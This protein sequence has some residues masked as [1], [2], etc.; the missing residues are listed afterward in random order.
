VAS[1]AL[2]QLTALG[3]ELGTYTPSG[4]T[5]TTIR[6]LVSPLRRTDT[7]GN[8]AFLSKT[9]E[10]WLVRSDSEGVSRVTV[11]DT[12]AI[13]LHPDDANE[14]LL[15]IAKLYPDRDFGIPGDGVGLWHVEAVQ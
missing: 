2:E 7:L 15:R 10:L 6:A 8:Q 5:P 3:G 12:F 11:G 4:G 14:T 1:I 13:R 9:F